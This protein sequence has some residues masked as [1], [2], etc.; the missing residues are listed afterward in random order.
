ML[1]PKTEEYYLD[2]LSFPS[3]SSSTG[4]GLSVI[5][6]IIA[7]LAVIAVLVGFLLNST[8]V[9]KQRLIDSWDSDYIPKDKKNDLLYL[10]L[11]HQWAQ[12]SLDSKGTK[13][14][15]STV[16]GIA[17]LD[18]AEK[19]RLYQIAL[20]AESN[21]SLAVIGYKLQGKLL[22]SVETG[23]SAASSPKLIAVLAI[24]DR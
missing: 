17:G 21:G 20:R 16:W 14:I 5:V 3:D 11:F 8:D 23:Q 18:G 24:H 9:E 1:G 6:V 13:S 4:A 10:K 7:V 19:W 15:N 12:N 22:K 2:E